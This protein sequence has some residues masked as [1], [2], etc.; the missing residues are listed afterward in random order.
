MKKRKYLIILISDNHAVLGLPLRVTVSLIIGMVALGAI[1]S[2]I[3]NPCLFPERLIVTVN[4]MVT[5]I[6]DNVTTNV[7]FLVHVNDT[8]GH[9]ITGAKVIIKGLGGGCCGFTDNK[10]R[11]SLVLQ[12]HLD[13]GIHEGY[14]GLSVDAAC[15]ESFEQSDIIK[16]VKVG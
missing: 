10:G 8:K 5:T 15:Y 1:L 6:S 4:P 12:V 11:T 2:Y 13:P 9:S 7:S 3:M 14:L 16:I